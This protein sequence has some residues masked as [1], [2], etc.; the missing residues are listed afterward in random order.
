MAHWSDRS[1]RGIAGTN[2]VSFSTLMSAAR[3]FDL[4]IRQRRRKLI[5]VG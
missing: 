5:D 4:A 1:G 2:C 3:Y